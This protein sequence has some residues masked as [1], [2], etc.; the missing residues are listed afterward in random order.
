MLMN[1]NRIGHGFA[2]AKH[3]EARRWALRENI[4]IEVCPISNQVLFKKKSAELCSRIF[5]DRKKQGDYFMCYFPSFDRSHRLPQKMKN[6][7]FYSGIFLSAQKK[8][9]DK[10]WRLRNILDVRIKLL[11]RQSMCKQMDSGSPRLRTLMEP[12]NFH[13]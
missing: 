10:R 6:T 1:T 2:L 5:W 7:R 8:R 3:S 4:A 9:K 12:R 11:S 13:C